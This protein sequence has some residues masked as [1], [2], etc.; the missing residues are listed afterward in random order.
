MV[1]HE[2]V[3]NTIRPNGQDMMYR[4]LIKSG[5]HR[6]RITIRSNSYKE[7]CYAGIERWDGNQWQQV[8]W[9]DG[10]ECATKAGLYVHRDR[11]VDL[12]HFFEDD[13]NELLWLAEQ[14]L[15]LQ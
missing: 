5:H 9:L 6:I 3:S 1:N 7:Q 14:I 10:G 4:E 11:P 12:G 8:W 15:G 2:T 13:R